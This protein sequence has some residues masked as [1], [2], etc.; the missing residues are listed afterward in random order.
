MLFRSRPALVIDADYLKHDPGQFHPESPER[1][2][3]LL[4]LPGELD[5]EGFQ[6][7][8]PRAALREELAACHSGDY[9]DL[10]QATSQR[11]RY[12]L[13]G[14]T[15][16]CRDSFGTGLL[17]AGGFLNLLDAIAAGDCPNGFALVRPPGHHALRD[18]AMGFCLFNTAAIAAHYLKRRHG[19]KRILIMDWDV[20]HGNGT[21]DAFYEDRSVL[22]CSTHQYPY[23]PGTGAAG[24]IG[25]GEGEGY[26][27]NIPLPAGCGDEEYLRAFRDVVMPIGSGF[28]PEWI[29]VSAG[30]D[31]HRR[32]PLGGMNLTERGFAAMASMLL[33]LGDRHARGKVAFLL[34]GG[35]DLTALKGSVVAVLQEMK[36]QGREEV[37]QGKGGE[38]IRPL[39]DS[40][41]GIQEKYW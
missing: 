12:A 35:Y 1:I 8:A 21:Q 16:T 23:Y 40:I 11:N 6:L 25:R 14:D 20:H 30:F 10:V 38:A 19:A 28:D 18:R 32:D 22:Y 31:P 5:S 17:A 41:R 7:L 15:V 27:V 29:L 33:G 24:E 26:T 37:A 9:I 39:I 4:D 13:D 3:A 36:E 34:E 2:K